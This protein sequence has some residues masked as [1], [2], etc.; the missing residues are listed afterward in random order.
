MS[1]KP[2]E[3]FY[4]TVNHPPPFLLEPGS[5]EL[6]RENRIKPPF[7]SGIEAAHL[8]WETRAHS[9][10]PQKQRRHCSAGNMHKAY[11]KFAAMGAAWGKWG[12]GFVALF[13]KCFLCKQKEFNPHLPKAMYKGQPPWR[14]LV[15]SAVNGD[16]GGPQELSG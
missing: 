15:I 16:T 6:P 5:W 2:L 3:P 11:L 12:L 1:K 7:D 8:C 14:E 13:L 10:L 9:Q 4:G